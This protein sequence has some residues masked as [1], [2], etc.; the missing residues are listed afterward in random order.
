MNILIHKRGLLLYLA[1]LAASL[2]FASFYGGPVSFGWLYAILLLIP[3]SIVYIFVNSTFLRI[4]QEVEVHK[5]TKGEE[6]G[7]RAS[8][9]NE[10]IFPIHRM[11]IYVYDDRCDL[12]EIT[13]G[14]EI[15]LNI[16][17]KKELLSGISCRFAGAYYVG[18]E[19]VAFDDPFHIFTY[20]REIPYSFRAVVSPQIT[21]I[22]SKALDLENIFNNPGF[23][24]QK[25]FEN[26]PG[27][28]LRTYQKG[29]SVSAIN[30]K[31]SARLSDL[32]VRVPDRMEKRAVTILMLASDVPERDQD[33]EFLKKRDSFLEFV[34][35]AAW[36]FGQQNV[37]V[38]IIYPSGK[39][40]EALVDSY[41]SFRE[42]YGIIADSVF[43]RS[44]SDYA[45]LQKLAD[46][47]RSDDLYDN[48]TWILV[49]ENTQPGQDDFCAC[50]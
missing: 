43:Y 32:V 15:S 7:F 9:E 47:K 44:E 28:D 4:Y 30:W 33:T 36:H 5:L 50:G 14:Q 35:S 20:E 37:P 6:H 29:D 1:V 12:Y 13:N 10:G 3:V 8:F 31:V 26:I 39:I 40:T 46:D 49:R 38:R 48:D 17:E 19:K 16:R 42:F 41:D 21:D 11:R 18:I 45:E 2:V 25:L 27:S 22:A 34:V 24:S 23:K